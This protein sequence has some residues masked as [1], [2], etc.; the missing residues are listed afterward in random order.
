M[1]VS[2]AMNKVSSDIVVS[3]APDA[4]KESYTVLHSA[5]KARTR[6]TAVCWTICVL[7]IAP[8]ANIA[9]KVRGCMAMFELVVSVVLKTRSEKEATS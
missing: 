5:T 4:V 1:I 6:R 3:M 2:H 8:D 9:V 7:R